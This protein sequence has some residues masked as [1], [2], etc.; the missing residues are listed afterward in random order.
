M[1]HVVYVLSSGAADWLSILHV[2]GVKGHMSSQCG[3][4]VSEQL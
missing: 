2:T 3:I 4:P 1:T